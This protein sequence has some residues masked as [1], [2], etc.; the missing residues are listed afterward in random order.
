M[1]DKV[2]PP[3]PSYSSLIFTTLSHPAPPLDPFIKISNLLVAVVLES[4]SQK[5]KT[6]LF[7]TLSPGSKLRESEALQKRLEAEQILLRRCAAQ[8]EGLK[9]TDQV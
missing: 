4:V 8:S 5:R 3:H 9:A 7:K 2:N 6:P 1:W